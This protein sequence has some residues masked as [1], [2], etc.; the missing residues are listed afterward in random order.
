MVDA[1]RHNIRDISAYSTVCFIAKSE[2]Q[3][4]YRKSLRKIVKLLPNL[5]W[6]NR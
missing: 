1:N 6:P 5:K 2:R 3:S 4:Q